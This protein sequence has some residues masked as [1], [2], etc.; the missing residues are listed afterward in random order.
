MDTARPT[1][2]IEGMRESWSTALYTLSK[3]EHC[4]ALTSSRQKDAEKMAPESVMARGQ[5]CSM[6]GAFWLVISIGDNYVH[7]VVSMY[8]QIREDVSLA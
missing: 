8:V 6:D 7:N 5:T 4:V 3:C 2:S 1:Q